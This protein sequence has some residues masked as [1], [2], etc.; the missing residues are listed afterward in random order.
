MNMNPAQRAPKPRPPYVAAEGHTLVT[1][2]EHVTEEVLEAVR[3]IESG[4]F[5]D[6]PIDWEAVWER[7]DGSTL[8]SGLRIDLGPEYGSPAMRKIQRVIRAERRAG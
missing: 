2:A 7:L 3:Q 5:N 8:D 1:E 4:W 6:K